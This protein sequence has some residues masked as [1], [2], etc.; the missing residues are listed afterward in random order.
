MLRAFEED[1]ESFP[2]G[3]LRIPESGNGVSDLLDEVKW[4]ADFL[5]KMQ[6]PDGSVLSRVQAEG[7]ANG[8]AP[9]SADQ[10]LRYYHDP[11]LD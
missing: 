6:L 7:Q 8:S 9:P 10:S 3:F 1:P 2:D 11:T 5:L 4:E